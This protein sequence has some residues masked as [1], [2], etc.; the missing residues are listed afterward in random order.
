[1][2]VPIT[3]LDMSDGYATTNARPTTVPSPEAQQTPVCFSAHT[4]KKCEP[5]VGI[6]SEANN[7][8]G[9]HPSLHV[10]FLLAV[11]FLLL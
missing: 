6:S 3:S 1:M 11:Q 5:Q 7:L 8:A 2:Q 10:L 9:K 4:E